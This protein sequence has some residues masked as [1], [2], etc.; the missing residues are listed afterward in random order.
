MGPS[1]TPNVMF[2]KTVPHLGTMSLSRPYR[3]LHGPRGL[4]H[5]RSRDRWLH[6]TDEETE[7]QDTTS[8]LESTGSA[9][10]LGF[11]SR[12]QTH[13]LPSL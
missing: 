13:T 2:P 8:L 3:P 11:E 12:T 4:C 5:Q 7:P 6:F 9:N 1:Y 10:R